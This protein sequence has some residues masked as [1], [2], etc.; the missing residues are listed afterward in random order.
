MAK[1]DYQLDYLEGSGRG[2]KEND[3]KRKKLFEL[4]ALLFTTRY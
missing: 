3:A 4:F 1:P 2:G